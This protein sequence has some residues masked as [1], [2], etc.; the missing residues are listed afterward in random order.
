MWSTIVNW[1]LEYTKD[2]LTM[3]KAKLYF[4]HVTTCYLLGNC[5]EHKGKPYG[6]NIYRTYF[7]IHCTHFNIHYT[8]TSKINTVAN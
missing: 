5:K 8:H 6:N 4:M 3:V 2:D 1:S 7:N